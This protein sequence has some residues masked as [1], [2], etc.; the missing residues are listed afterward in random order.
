MR[1]CWCCHA[2][3]MGGEP[4]PF[5]GQ[6]LAS[7]RKE[8]LRDFP[9]PQR[10]RRLSR[11]G[12]ALRP[13]SVDPPASVAGCRR[14]STRFAVAGDAQMGGVGH[15]QGGIQSRLGLCRPG[16]LPA[17][18]PVQQAGARGEGSGAQGG[19]ALLQPVQ[20]QGHGLDAG[21][22]LQGEHHGQVRQEQR[23]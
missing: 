11:A 5:E 23:R 14:Y 2:R 8:P 1:I 7:V 10:M 22:A 16:H 20:G 15:A 18:P 9:I 17:R 6:K 4:R 21:D 12:F 3:P 19:E 13:I